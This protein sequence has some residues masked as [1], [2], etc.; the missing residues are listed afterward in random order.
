MSGM[1]V[2]GVIGIARVRLALAM[3]AIAALGLA[4]EAAGSHN[5]TTLLSQGEGACAP[6]CGNGAFDVF[7]TGASAEGAR[8]FFHTQEA[9]VGED[10]DTMQQDVYERSGGSTTWVSADGDATN[11]DAI[12]G[13]AST[14]GTRVFFETNEALDPG[15]DDLTV[16]VYE[17]A[18]GTT[19]GISTDGDEEVDAQFA[20][21]S[22]DG[23]RVFFETDE[24]LGGDGDTTTDVYE[25]SGG[26]TTG[27]STDG[28]DSDY[29]ATFAGASEDGTK[30]FF[31]TEQ[32][33]VAADT[34]IC[35]FG[36]DPVGCVDV[37]QRSAAT[38]TGI[39]TEDNNFSDTP[40]LGASADG[41]RVFFPASEQLVDEDDDSAVDIYERSGGTTTGRST[42][43]DGAFSATFAGASVDGSRVF[44]HTNEPLSGDTDSSQ[45]VYVHSAGGATGISTDGDGAFPATFAGASGDGS[46]VFFET[47]E[48]I[49]GTGDGDS[50]ADV[51]ER[52]AGTTTG[53]ST[54]GDSAIGAV[55]CSRIS[56]RDARVLRDRG[57]AGRRGRRHDE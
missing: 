44:F 52:S 31:E 54:G 45:D 15:D 20:G 6:G 2:V 14:D 10:G 51:Y 3:A 9:L 33:L 13:G 53:I 37:Y 41:T 22:A 49:P 18:G 35:D 19:T 24:A 16:D 8:V 7:F 57:V 21:A 32:S 12:F 39:S 38:T 56:R 48:P 27:I 42:D 46:R 11:A 40:F 55:L 29:P 1:R 26:T 50:S 28:D 36:F 47:D 25:H 34:D 5:T 4:S 30:V 43:G 23:T 17:R